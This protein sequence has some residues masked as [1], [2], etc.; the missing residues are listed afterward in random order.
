MMDT[1]KKEHMRRLLDPSIAAIA[2]LLVIL[3]PFI[4]LSYYSHP[5][6]DDFSA[7][8]T[9]VRLGYFKAVASVYNVWNGR[10]FS[11][12]LMQANPMA[13]GSI[14][15]CKLIPVAIL[16]LLFWALFTLIKAVFPQ[17][18]HSRERFLC[19]L[20]LLALYLSGMPSIVQ[21]FYWI[22]GAI[23]YQLANALTLFLW[24]LMT[25]LAEAP[26][27]RA[28]KWGFTAAAILVF[29]VTGSNETHMALILFT[30]AAAL[31][32]RS[33]IKGK[34]DRLFAGLLVLAAIASAI[35]VI[36][37]G[38]YAR[39]AH[40]ARTA[41]NLAGTLSQSVLVMARLVRDQ[42]TNP[43]FLI[44]T[45]CAIP[46]FAAKLQ[47][48]R[49]PGA[50]LSPGVF[51]GIWIC[52]M[53]ATVVPVVR[54][55]G[56]VPE[57]ILNVTSLIFI[58]GWFLIVN[59]IVRRILL[60]GSFRLA[61]APAPRYVIAI[62]IVLVLFALSGSNNIRAAWGNLL[63]GTA[64]RYDAELRRRYDEIKSCPDKTCVVPPLTAF[65]SLL[66]Y[67]DINT[68]PD[69]WLNKPYAEYFGKQ[70]IMLAKP[71]K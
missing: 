48:S 45:I 41:T 59:E 51:S 58:M 26:A 23:N 70:A 43:L 71:E 7:A 12:A 47:N 35:V 69:S 28:G 14:S 42:A 15:S 32:W 16:V 53:L 38:N 9:T 13:F 61:L 50:A 6:A 5:Q 40:D 25:K 4:I 39:M 36:A 1:M 68:E 30:F 22:S 44:L 55:L 24:A 20:A 33:L 27:N 49:G 63:D 2:I 66:Y 17:I 10:W 46:Y 18:H 37:P 11:T 57:R 21:G 52:S 8:A 31:A 29:A 3:L 56:W 19:A 64:S 65:P 62:V 34:M 60:K 67:E 54:V